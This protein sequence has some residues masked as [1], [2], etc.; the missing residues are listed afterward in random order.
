MP[1]PL[2][3]IVYPL[4]LIIH[5]IIILLVVF[6]CESCKWNCNLYSRISRNTYLFLNTCYCGCNRQM[7]SLFQQ[8]RKSA[9]K[10]KAVEMDIQEKLYGDKGW[11]LVQLTGFSWIKNKIIEKYLFKYRKKKRLIFRLNPLTA[12][13]KGCYNCVKVRVNNDVTIIRG[14]TMKELLLKFKTVRKVDLLDAT[15]INH[16]VMDVL[17]CEYCYRSYLEYYADDVLLPPFRI[18]LELMSCV[19]FLVSAWIPLLIL[20]ALMTFIERLGYCCSKRT[21]FMHP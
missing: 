12:Y 9:D 17:F 10:N 2:N 16:L 1:P 4:G 5:I 20:F 13:H 14:I 11:L 8:Q 19:L 15:L 6:Q 3:V 21:Y 7:L 18:L